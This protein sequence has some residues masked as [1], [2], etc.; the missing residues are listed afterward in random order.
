MADTDPTPLTEAEQIP[1]ERDLGEPEDTIAGPG[2]SDAPYPDE[3]PDADSDAD[4][5]TR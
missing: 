2:G 1:S 4:A 5:D 3:D